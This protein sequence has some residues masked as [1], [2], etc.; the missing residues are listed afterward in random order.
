MVNELS[1]LRRRLT[2]TR[3]LLEQ[4]EKTVN[5]LQSSLDCLGPCR[6]TDENVIRWM[7]SDIED[8]L[9]VIPDDITMVGEN[10]VPWNQLYN[11][12]E[13][14]NSQVW[15]SGCEWIIVGREGWT[16]EGLEGLLKDR[17]NS[18][19]RIVSQ[20]LFLAAVISGHDP[21]CADEE[22]LL[23]FA[24]GHPAL[25]YLLR[26]GFE[27]PFLGEELTDEPDFFNSRGADRSPLAEMGYH[28]GLTNG[29]PE[30]ER[31][32]LLT[33][34]YSEPLPWVDS[35]DYME[36]WGTSRSRR[37]LWRMA[38]HLAWLIRTRQGLPN[39]DVAVMEWAEDLDWLYDEYYY[40]WMRFNWPSSYVG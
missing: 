4:T 12:L 23:T 11:H 29:L 27:W 26:A 31:H 37:R 34:A 21:F 20:E 19:I 6:I 3:N 38:H 1:T 14:W 8:D 17:T 18:E 33:C 35:D 5:S 7:A 32:E 22:I 10:P 16:E 13:E 9:F 25:E 24:E 40:P 2:R 15:D 36:Q 30:E 39:L 28:V